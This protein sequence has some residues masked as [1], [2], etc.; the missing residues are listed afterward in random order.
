M[1]HFRKIK[2]HRKTV[3]VVPP[4]NPAKSQ[5]QQ[6]SKET[7]D[8]Q[9]QI[10][11]I[12]LLDLQQPDQIQQQK[13]LHHEE[14]QSEPSSQ[15]DIQL[16][17]IERIELVDKQ[18]EHQQQQNSDTLD[19]HHQ[20]HDEQHR[21]DEKQTKNEPQIISLPSISILKPLMGVDT[22]LQNNLETFFTMNYHSVIFLNPT[23][24][25]KISMNFSNFQYELLFCVERES[26]PA[27]ELVGSLI[28]K[29]PTVDARL[30]IG[31]FII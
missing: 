31:M 28:K 7:Q 13:L 2:L 6:N 23:R 18:P 21:D 3:L 12:D 5:N 4:K 30:F 14:H 8:K 15:N 11:Q 25:C 20:Q 10:Q 22:N 19:H 16:Y 9:Q 29:Y 17:H 1:F 27:V 26:D 24:N